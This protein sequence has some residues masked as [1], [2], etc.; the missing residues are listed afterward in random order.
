MAGQI[1][2]RSSRLVSWLALAAMSGGALCARQQPP[3]QPPPPTPQSPPAQTEK[4][5]K[6]EQ[7]ATNLPR[8]KKLILKDGSVQVVREYART[9]ETVRYY[10]LQESQWEEV[11]ASIVDWDATKKA[12]DE[13]EAKEKEFASRI[14]TQEKNRDAIPQLDIDASL[15][16]APGVI[17]PQDEGM[18]AL[19]GTKVVQLSETK[20]EI[21]VDKGRF[22]EKVLT[23]IPIVPERQ[24]VVIKGKH[25]PIRLGDGELQFYYRINVEDAEPTVELLRSVQD[26]DFRRVEWIVTPPGSDKQEQREKIS[27]LKWQVAKGVFRFTVNQAIEPGEYALA[28]VLQDGLN[29]FVWDFGVDKTPH[30]PTKSK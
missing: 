17:L 4:Q 8:G 20:T 13:R 2:Y 6:G 11:P 10:S 27:V 21:K 23:P 30:T 7:S 3:Q 1:H 24:R 28:V 12:E 5:E 16:V 25:S 22:V 18:F 26:G 15:E 14:A 9:G 29:I 19:D